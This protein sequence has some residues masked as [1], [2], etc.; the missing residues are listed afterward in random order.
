MELGLKYGFIKQTKHC[1]QIGT[2]TMLELQPAV[3][4]AVSA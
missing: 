3:I 2:F 1:P 4:R